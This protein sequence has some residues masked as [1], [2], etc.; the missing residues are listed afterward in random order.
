M[1]SLTDWMARTFFITEE[2]EAVSAEVAANHQRILD[3]QRDEGKVGALEY[4][5]TTAEIQN[6][7]TRYFDEQLGKKGLPGL[8]ATIPWWV[9][10]IVAVGAAIWFWP[11]LRPFVGKVT[12]RFHK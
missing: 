3:R 11:V 10:L 1:A 9:W 7:G 2:Q 6:T 8:A 5:E 12:K 4:L